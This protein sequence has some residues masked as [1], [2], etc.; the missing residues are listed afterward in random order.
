MTDTAIKE[1]GQ[2]EPIVRQ[3]DTGDRVL[4]GADGAVNV[5]YR[6]LAN[7]TLWLKKTLE[8]RTA[9]A[10]DN[11]AGVAKLKNTLDSSDTGAALTAAQGKVLNDKITQDYLPLTGGTIN[12]SLTVQAANA[13]YAGIHINNTDTGA[14]GS[15]LGL[16]VGGMMRGGVEIFGE[17][18]GSYSVALTATA[19]GDGSDRHERVLSA[20]AGY[21]WTR[22]YGLLHDYFARKTDLTNQINNLRNEING[23]FTHSNYPSHYAGAEVW[24]L[25]N[26][27]KITM[28]Q[29]T[30]INASGD[31]YL[32]EAYQGR[33]IAV[34][35]DVGDGRRIVSSYVYN[36]TNRIKIF[37]SDLNVAVN[38]IV[39]GWANH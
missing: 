39:V 12:G 2:W 14:L 35:N 6:Q 24:R 4:G 18:E 19:K 38:I 9:A 23:K 31:Y 15:F 28:M 22:A 37:V 36:G 34:A 11:K 10:T 21:V 27:L 17:G 13:Q 25:P 16:D 29:V 5:A 32:P 26:G 20:A 30:G 1:T 3:V 33:A 7:R 8:D